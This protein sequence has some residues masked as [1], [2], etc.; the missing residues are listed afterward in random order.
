[1]LESLCRV[2]CPTHIQDVESDVATG[3][4][5]GKANDIRPGTAGE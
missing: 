5:S 2:V 3:L 1:M 4:P